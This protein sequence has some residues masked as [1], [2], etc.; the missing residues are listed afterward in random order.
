MKRSDFIVSVLTIFF[1]LLYFP[2]D[3]HAATY[4]VTKTSDTID[5]TCDAD[6][7]I[8]EAITAA[9]ANAGAD[10]IEFAIPESDDGYVDPTSETHG[11]FLINSNL[12]TL[13]DDAGVFI[14]GYSQSGSAR[15][16]AVFG[17]T[18]NTVLKIRIVTPTTG[19]ITLMT[20]DNNHITGIN[21]STTRTGSSQL[22]ISTSSN[23]WIEGNFFGSTIDGTQAS[24]GGG[25]Y[26]I[27]SADANV[28]GTNGDGVGDAGERNLFMSNAI[29]TGGG[30]TIITTNG[31]AN[32]SLV[33]AGNYFGVD[34]TGR[35]CTDGVI[36]GSMIWLGGATGLDVTN[37]Q[38]GTNLDGVSDAEEANI[39]ACLD[40]ANERTLLRISSVSN[41]TIQGNYLGTNPYGDALDSSTFIRG[42][43]VLRDFNSGSVVIKRNTIAHINGVGIGITA[44]TP[45]ITGITMSENVIHHTTGVPIGLDFVT[46]EYTSI[47]ENDSEDVDT[48]TNELMNFPVITNV[49]Y[50]GHNNYLVEG[51]FDGNASEGPFT[52]EI[53]LAEDNASNH[54]GCL[55]TLGSRTFE[56]GEWATT[57][58]VDDDDGN[59][60]RVFTSLATN[61]DGSTSEFSENYHFGTPSITHTT[62]PTI[63]VVPGCTATAPSIPPD[64]YQI[65]VSDTTALLRF[66]PAGNPI[67]GYQISYGFGDLVERFGTQFPY[68]ESNG[69]IEYVI[70]SLQPN[71]A[72]YFKVRGVNSCQP[73]AWS[74]SLI[75]T[76]DTR[77]SRGG[78]VFFAY[79]SLKQRVANLSAW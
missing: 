50:I 37:A 9:N 36:S 56:V 23:N 25:F 31:V 43:L 13:S 52:L 57:V 3:I 6:C 30:A 60:Y 74:N 18:M 11:Y 58:H 54:G 61:A 44:T 59:Q 42:A 69:S 64:L 73:G 32:D 16:T 20:G 45:V 10:T 77:K 68:G 21:F 26:Y 65:N 53:C 41:S 76:T 17:E 79:T 35:V 4:T 5:G 12:V 48:G 8:R 78:I 28:F 24:G 14:N 46:A 7:S 29:G 51:T 33:I 27:S 67:T 22:G 34:K 38:I 19:S 63:P 75:I 72:Y 55:Q 49:A 15:N 1:V 62:S 66:A 47:T 40:A 2:R 70:G 71:T 39:L